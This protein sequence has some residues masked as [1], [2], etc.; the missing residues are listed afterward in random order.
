MRRSLPGRLQFFCAIEA[1][2]QPR[3]C[4]EG[5][6]CPQGTAT[7]L[8]CEAG[9]FGNVAGLSSAEQCIRAS[10]GFHASAGSTSQTPCSRGTAAP[11][12]GMGVCDE[13]EPGQ[14]QDAPGQLS[15]RICSR[16]S[17]SAN[18]LSC[19]LCQIGE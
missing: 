4:P 13:C 19:E 17:Y 15:C 14:Y 6:F 7:P 18:V 9:T 3:L 12:A 1:T 10:A 8:L 2:V 5:R 11:S 16:G